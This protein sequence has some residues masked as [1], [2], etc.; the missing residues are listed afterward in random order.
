MTPKWVFVPWVHSGRGCTCLGGS[1][2]RPANV[3]VEAPCSALADDT[4][5]ERLCPYTYGRTMLRAGDKQLRAAHG[6]INLREPR[7]QCLASSQHLPSGASREG[8]G[9]G[10][11]ARVTPE[12][13]PPSQ[14]PWTWSSRTPPRAEP[15]YEDRLS[16]KGD[17]RASQLRSLTG[18]VAPH[19]LVPKG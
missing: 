16:I 17:S 3:P 9:H 15:R 12:R 10:G 4:A 14:V 1:S 5:K 6:Y 11:C 18:H 8:A 19:S 13:T 7:A 2:R